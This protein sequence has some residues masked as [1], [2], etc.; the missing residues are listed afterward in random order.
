MLHTLRRIVNEVNEAQNLA[1]ALRIIV[2]RVKE[3][4]DTDVC[5]VYLTDAASGQ[6]VLMATDGLNP[7]AVGRLRLARGEGLVSVVAETQE[8]LNLD[9]APAHPRFSYCAESG[10]SP[11]RT[12]LGVPIIHHRQVMGILIVQHTER[13]FGEDDVSFLL[14]VASQLAGA[15]AHADASGGI[16]GLADDAAGSRHIDGL[17]GAPGVGLGTAVVVY[18]PA[19]LEAIPDRAIQDSEKEVAIFLAA[20]EA[21]RRE[22]RDL[23]RR[24]NAALSKEDRA[25]FEAY[26][27]MLDSTTLEQRT[28]ENIRAGNWAAGALRATIIEHA[29]IFDEMDDPYISERAG[30]I[31]DVGR[32]ILA[33]IQNNAT[34][35]MDYPEQTILVGE[36]IS[37]T[38]LSQAPL[39]RL[40]GVVSGSGSTSSHVAILA[41]ALGIPAVVGA[42]YLPVSRI[43]GSEL[44]VD[45]YKGRVYISPHAAVRDEYRRLAREEEELAA[46]LEELST[47]PAITRD[48]VRVPLYANT[49]LL[50]DINPSLARGAE[51][52]GLYRTEF[53][54]MMRQ[55]FPGE[56]EQCRIYRRV[57]EAFSPRPVYLRTLDIGGDKVLPYF[58]IHEDNPFLGWRGIRVTLDHPEIFVVQLRAILRASAG[59]DN[60]RLLLPMVSHV[61]EVDQARDIIV[62][63][64]TELKEAGEA[65][66]MPETGIMIEVPSMLYQIEDLASRVDFFSVGTNDLTQYLLA[67]DRNNTRVAAL[68]DTLHPALLRALAQVVLAAQRHGKPVSVCGEMAG[69]PAAAILLLGMGISSFSTTAASLPR[70]K[71]V[72]CNFSIAEAR[73]ILD[74]V[75]LME[76]SHAIRA[77][78]NDRLDSAGLGSLVRAGK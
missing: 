16:K 47:R 36:E 40:A 2:R 10:E 20:L 12:F 6:Y 3:A 23:S 41:R 50:S 21:A 51:G 65:I 4:M 14:T 27:L 53:P 34:S 11:Y 26:A 73:N 61:A 46:G 72:I 15:I 19:N 63:V 76:D 75:L 77:F 29:R 13:S 32:R 60:L 5:S 55:Q 68:Y 58:P 37:V 66:T 22:I 39:E 49:G 18:P 70:I 67:V 8:P 24:M 48:G 44:I 43:D 9:D 1:E 33:H 52:V 57:L 69:D 31:R 35:Q 56:E 25:L 64:F 71:W 59:L 28:I 30:D 74:E 54:F 78:L 7:Q 62:R 42:S 17:P 45:G 38:E